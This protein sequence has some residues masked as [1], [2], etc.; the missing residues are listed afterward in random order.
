[1]RGVFEESGDDVRIV[2]N[3]AAVRAAARRARTDRPGGQVSL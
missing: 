3:R 1:M 2:L